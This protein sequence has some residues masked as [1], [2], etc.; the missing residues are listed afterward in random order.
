MTLRVESTMPLPKRVR[1]LIAKAKI[2]SEKSP[3]PSST[4]LAGKTGLFVSI[5]HLT[6]QNHVATCLS[7]DVRLRHVAYDGERPEVA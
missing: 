6:H 2:D 5:G 3:A 4:V 1:R 7:P